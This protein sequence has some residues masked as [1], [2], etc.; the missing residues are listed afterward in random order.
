V[1][2]F[3]NTFSPLGQAIVVVMALFVGAVLAIAFPLLPRST[4]SLPGPAMSY[5]TPRHPPQHE[6][7][8]QVKRPRPQPQPV[9]PESEFE[10]S[11]WWKCDPLDPDT[12]FQGMRENVQTFGTQKPEDLGYKNCIKN[13]PIDDQEGIHPL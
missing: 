2:S 5:E 8:A 4:P 6:Q 13:P 12:I 3:K 11:T 10:T 9:R 7:L 1:I